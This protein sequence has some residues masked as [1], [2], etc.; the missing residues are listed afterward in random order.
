MPSD[1]KWKKRNDKEYHEK[2]SF[3]SYSWVFK[4]FMFSFIFEKTSSSLPM[5][6]VHTGKCSSE[7][8][9]SSRSQMFFEIGVLKNF[10]M[11]AKKHLCSSLFLIKLGPWRSVFLLKTRFQHRCFPV[12]IPEFLRAAFLWNTFCS[13]SDYKILWTSLGTILTCFIFLVLLLCFPSNREFIVISLV[14]S[15]VHS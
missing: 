9:R 7:N 1:T 13:Y 11:L 5:L 3:F 8:L 2:A 12:N 14:I 6:F 15:G 10:P 4:R